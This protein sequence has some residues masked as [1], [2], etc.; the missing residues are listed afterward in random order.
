MVVAG[1]C[2]RYSQLVKKFAP[3]GILRILAVCAKEP[4]VVLTNHLVAGRIVLHNLPYPILGSLKSLLAAHVLVVEHNEQH[5]SVLEKV[6]YAKF[7]L[8]AVK[9]ICR[10]IPEELVGV[11]LVGTGH[12]VVVSVHSGPHV[13]LEML[14]LV[15]VLP[16][17]VA[18]APG[19]DVSKVK[20]PVERFAVL[21]Y[22]RDH[23]HGS[24]SPSIKGRIC[25]E[26]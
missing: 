4:L 18:S 22:R 5:I 20:H 25:M 6:A 16:E 1:Q 26:I 11:P 19:S 21:P 7:S 8:I 15:K 2:Q 14:L 23:L 10:R 24:L 9:R 12:V 3:S 17:R 13:V